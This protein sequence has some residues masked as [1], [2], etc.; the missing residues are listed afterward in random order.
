M[1]SND[2]S[3]KADDDTDRQQRWAEDYGKKKK[4]KAGKKARWLGS[5]S[6]MSQLRAYIT[7]KTAQV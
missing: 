1:Q 4:K 2:R 6:V 3:I 5:P 7:N